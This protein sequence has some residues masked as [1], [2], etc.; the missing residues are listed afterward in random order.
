M[1]LLAI[2]SSAFADDLQSGVRLPGAASV[3]QPYG[4]VG[5]G[6]ECSSEDGCGPLLEAQWAPTTELGF[7][8]EIPTRMDLDRDIDIDPSA[9]VGARYLVVDEAAIRVAPIALVG[10]TDQV[11]GGESKAIAGALGA[12][13]EIGPEEVHAY[14]EAPLLAVSAGGRDRAYVD[15]TLANSEAGVEVEA[16]DMHQFTV[17]IDKLDPAASYRLDAEQFYGEAE[18]SWAAFDD[19]EV[20]GQLSAGV[21]F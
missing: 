12:A 6:V 18:V 7:T 9:L 15:A 1:F 17:G 2:I 10:T 4:Q 16:A 20:R 14:V 21:T 5:A 11:I 13:A 3:D 8:A 19:E